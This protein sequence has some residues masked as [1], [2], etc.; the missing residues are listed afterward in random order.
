MKYKKH[1]TTTPINNTV[2]VLNP[3][4]NFIFTIIAKSFNLAFLKR[5]TKNKI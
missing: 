1:S 4:S 2:L 3:R 5:Q